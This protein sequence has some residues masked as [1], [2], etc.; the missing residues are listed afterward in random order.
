MLMSNQ[1]LFSDSQALTATAASTNIIDLTATGTV[2]GAP[3]ALVRDIGKGNPIP[4]S[5]R[6]MVASGGTSPTL[7]VAVQVDTVA[8]FSSPTTVLTSETFA[9]AAA[10][11]E[12]YIEVYL[13]ETVS[14]RFL[15]LN[16]TLGGTSPTFTVT[17]GIV[18]AKSSNVTV[19]GA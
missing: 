8:A 12:A 9:G 10:G 2:L 15:R 11:D 16:Y 7:V 5:V 18:M 14:Q 19:P 13:P 17:A 4:L 6:H 1:Q 3:T